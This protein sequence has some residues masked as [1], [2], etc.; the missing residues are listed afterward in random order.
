MY[1]SPDAGWS[2]EED[3]GGVESETIAGAEYTGDGLGLDPTVQ[4]SIVSS[5]Q[6]QLNSL[7]PTHSP[8]LSPRNSTFD[9]ITQLSTAIA[10]TSTP[11]STF[12]S[13][14]R[15]PEAAEQRKK[16][17]QDLMVAEATY[18]TDLRA[19]YTSRGGGLG[20]SILDPSLSSRN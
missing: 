20:S 17:I 13:R 8:G 3:E 6:Q 15:N 10:S 1:Y 11:R 14:S 4:D 9:I 7:A 16:A 18:A 12:P 19:I 2:D 5:M